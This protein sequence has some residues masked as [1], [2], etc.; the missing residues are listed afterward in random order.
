[1][2]R[3]ILIAQDDPAVGAAL[4]LFLQGRGF[5][6]DT[7][8]DVDSVS[9][10][11]G[12]SRCDAILYG[13]VDG[14]ATPELSKRLARD[15]PGV[16]AIPLDG[17]GARLEGDGP[18]RPVDYESILRRIRDAFPATIEP[19]TDT[20][21]AP[22]SAAEPFVGRSR[23]MKAVSDMI[24]RLSDSASTVLITGESGTGK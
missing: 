22:A 9:R 17:D 11:L 23:A 12:L 20:R 21:P 14:A 16:V 4:S 8:R 15:F 19:A 24:K 5:E 18:A 2:G 7:A 10:H 6:C 13:G 3:S 1:M